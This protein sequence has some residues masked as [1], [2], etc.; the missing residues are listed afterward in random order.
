MKAQITAGLH[1]ELDFQ[2]SQILHFPLEGLLAAGHSIA[3][4]A[5]LGTVSQIALMDNG[6]KLVEQQVFAPGEIC[7]LKPLLQAYPDYCPTEVLLANVA[8]GIVTERAIERSR[9]RLHLALDTGTWSQATAPVR[10][11]LSRVRLKMHLFDIDIFTIIKVGY[12]LRR[13]PGQAR[14]RVL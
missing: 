11:I 6:P 3:V 4:H 1:E 9:R 5:A 8:G 12:G 7:L 13:K 2:E 10:N 14:N